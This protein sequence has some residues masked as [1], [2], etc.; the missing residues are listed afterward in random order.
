MNH[1]FYF[2]PVI[3]EEID[4]IAAKSK[5]KDGVVF[6]PEDFIW[7]IQDALLWIPTSNPANNVEWQGRG[8]NLYGP[9]VIGQLGAPVAQK[10]FSFWSTLL[11]VGPEEITLRGPWVFE[12]DDVFGQGAYSSITF[13]RDDI[14]SKLREIES[15]AALTIEAKGC[16]LHLG[17]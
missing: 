9:T 5:Y 15:F 8:L 10:I 17:I 13:L 3:D 4:Y 1:Q 7:Y 11:D 12:Q 2:I 16:I 6:L 14:S